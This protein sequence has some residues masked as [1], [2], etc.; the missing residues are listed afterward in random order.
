[1][2]GGAATTVQDPVLAVLDTPSRAALDY[3]GGIPARRVS[4]HPDALAALADFDIEPP[5]GPRP[6]EVVTQLHRPGPRDDCLGGWTL[7]RADR[8]RHAAGRRCAVPLQRI[9]WCSTT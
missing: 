7:L 6:V 9:R 5:D 2:T 8:R 4:P 1:M 3:L